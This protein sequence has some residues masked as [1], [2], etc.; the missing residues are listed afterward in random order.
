MTWSWRERLPES[1][2]ESWELVWHVPFVAG[3]TWCA[4]AFCI[5]FVVL[6]LWHVFY[7]FVPYFRQHFIHPWL[8]DINHFIIL[9]FI[10]IVLS[11]NHKWRSNLKCISINYSKHHCPFLSFISKPLRVHFCS[12]TIP[13]WYIAIFG[14]LP[15][16]ICAQTAWC[17]AQ[18]PA[19]QRALSATE[20]EFVSPINEDNKLF[21]FS[22]WPA[23]SDPMWLQPS[24]NSFVVLVAVR[25]EAYR[26]ACVENWSCINQAVRLHTH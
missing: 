8:D 26:P 9:G 17:L 6:A 7:Y 3:W 21:N 12:L 10:F 22:W 1:S 20:R 5:S 11:V 2:E 23:E 13:S 24:A 15:Y 4:A 19:P 16:V 25:K 18:N 14:S